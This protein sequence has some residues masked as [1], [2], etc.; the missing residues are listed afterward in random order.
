MEYIRKRWEDKVGIWQVVDGGVT[1]PQG[2]QAAGVSAGIKKNGKRDLALIYAEKPC[3]AAG[4]FTQNLVKAAPVL[5]DME[6][7]EKTQGRAQAIV[8]NSGNA[9][10]CTGAQGR[11]DAL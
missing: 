10:A 3:S 8:V 1:A 2:F 6:H 7:L 4:V 5:L 9:N 11:Q